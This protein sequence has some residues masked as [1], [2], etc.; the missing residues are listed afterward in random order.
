ML[1]NQEVKT[2]ET[3]FATCGLE[4]GRLR[5][6]RYILLGGCL[7]FLF[8]GC[9]SSVAPSASLDVEFGT[10]LG[11]LTNQESC[12]AQVFSPLPIGDIGCW[13]LTRSGISELASSDAFRVKMSWDGQQLSLADPL[14]L[15]E[16]PFST[17]DRFDM[18]LVLFD[19]LSTAELCEEIPIEPSCSEIT[20]CVAKMTRRNTPLSFGERL[21]FKNEL[22]QCTVDTPKII[23]VEVCDGVVD[24]DCD[25]IIDEACMR[26]LDCISG[27]TI[28]CETQCGE[29]QQACVDGLFT[30]CTA[31]RPSP[32]V[33]AVAGASGE[34]EDC[35]GVIDEGCSSCTDGETRPCANR[36]GVAGS[37]RCERGEFQACDAPSVSVEICD[38]INDEDC[39]GSIDE[40]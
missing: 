12:S 18:R 13:A 2:T 5:C 19:S 40:G 3:T 39:D 14:A 16:F 10:C 27:E 24:D 1:H 33:C 32:E 7:F 23:A 37:E 15:S 30:E 4:R 35:D 6:Y 20:G 11:E 29:G 25:G 17:G 28:T 26:P 21:S 9:Q 38:G 34:D 8:L 22:G 36:C 31:R